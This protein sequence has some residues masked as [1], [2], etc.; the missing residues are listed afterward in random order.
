MQK[1]PPDVAVTL[2]KFLHGGEGILGVVTSLAGSLVLTDRRLV[3]VREGHEYRP[4][5]GI[6]S[7]DLASRVDFRY[8]PPR[9][10]MGRLV[11]GDGKAAT[12]FFVRK[13]DW[14]ETLR[15]ITM[16]RS[17]ARRARND[18]LALPTP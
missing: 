12:S 9:G 16:A 4:Q 2:A 18:A 13:S 8:G 17:I 14:T 7:W 15:L 11:V 6:R 5:S 10:G 1:S 3:I